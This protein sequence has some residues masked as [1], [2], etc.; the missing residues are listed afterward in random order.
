MRR[1]HLIE[2]GKRIPLKEQINLLYKILDNGISGYH[3]N[4]YVLSA[5][6]VEDRAVSTGRYCSR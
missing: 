3:F 1:E 2:A 5:A 4:F 6:P